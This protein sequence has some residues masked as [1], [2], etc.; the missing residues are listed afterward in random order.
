M[1][2]SDSFNISGGSFKTNGSE[3]IWPNNAVNISGG[4]LEASNIDANINLSY[5]NTDDYIKVD[6]YTSGKTMTIANG[7]TFTDGT[8][9]YSGTITNLSPLN[10]KKLFPFVYMH[11]T[12]RDATCTEVGIKQECW[13]RSSDGKYFSDANGTNELNASDVETPM[14]PH[15]G[16]RNDATDTHIEY[17]QCSVCSKYFSNS[18]CTTEIT[19]ED[20]KIYRTITIDDGI[21]DYVTSNVN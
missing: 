19:E 3:G 12:V 14:I 11:L 10:G 15:T 13:Q 6:N 21:R 7:Q 1:R 16:V 5:S 17:W 2:C 18:G 20:T 9:N 4:M 8:T